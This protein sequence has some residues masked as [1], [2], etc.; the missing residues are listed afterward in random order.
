ME[1][2]AL[3]ISDYEGGYMKLIIFVLLFS[4]LLWSILLWY[5]SP[6]NAYYNTIDGCIHGKKAV[7]FEFGKVCP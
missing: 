6:G 3:S 5:L 4:L 2:E 1:Q 7:S